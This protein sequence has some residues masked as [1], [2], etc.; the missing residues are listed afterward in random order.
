MENGKLA[1]E[2]SIFTGAA[3][4][5][6]P[7]LVLCLLGGHSVPCCCGFNKDMSCVLAAGLSAVTS[8]DSV[9]YKFSLLFR[10]YTHCQRKTPMLESRACR[11]TN[12]PPQVTVCLL[13][14]EL[15]AVRC[16][17]KQKTKNMFLV[18]IENLARIFIKD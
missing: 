18:I 17:K 14:T 15:F 1:L 12:Q 13:T 9:Y 2:L 4:S 5:V 16:K 7:L 10:S 8:E 6:L 3:K 11:G